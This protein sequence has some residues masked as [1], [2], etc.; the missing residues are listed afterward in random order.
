MAASHLS[1]K[2]QTD[3]TLSRIKQWKPKSS[4]LPSAPGASLTA[5]LASSVPLPAPRPVPAQLTTSLNSQMHHQNFSYPNLF[6]LAT[7]LAPKPAA[8]KEKGGSP[9][10]ASTSQSL[11]HRLLS[12]SSSFSFKPFISLHFHLKLQFIILSSYYF[13]RGRSESVDAETW[14]KAPIPREFSSLPSPSDIECIGQCYRRSYTNFIC[15]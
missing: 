8:L 15:T 11:R 9:P 2:D 6:P 4:G 13:R 3:L 7:V 5:L 10:S 12:R 14:S 1:L